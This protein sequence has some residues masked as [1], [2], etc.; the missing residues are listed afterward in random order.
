MQQTKEPRR[1]S[2]VRTHAGAAGAGPDPGRRNTTNGTTPT[3]RGAAPVPAAR[4]GD[5]GDATIE[6]IVAVLAIVLVGVVSAALHATP[7]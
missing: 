4:P 6:S 5:P 1:P 2:A 3:R 7:F